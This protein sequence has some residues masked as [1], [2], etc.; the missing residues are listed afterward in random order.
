M[1]A[2]NRKSMWFTDQ[3]N[4]DLDTLIGLLKQRSLVSVS[5]M[6]ALRYAMRIAIKELQ[7]EEAE[8]RPAT[9]SQSQRLQQ[10]NATGR[11][12]SKAQQVGK[13]TPKYEKIE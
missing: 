9:P 3:D 7:R 13:P 10:P 6:A 4:D 12:F 2:D 11:E 1:P 8:S 5:Q